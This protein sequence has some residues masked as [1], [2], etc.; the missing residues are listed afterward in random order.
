LR[1]VAIRRFRQS[2]VPPDGDSVWADGRWDRLADI[3]GS[4]TIGPQ[5]RTESSSTMAKAAGRMSEDRAATMALDCLAFLA[6]R[7]DAFERFSDLT[8]LDPATIAARA[9]ELDFLVAVT[10]FLLS[11]EGL[12]IDFCETGSVDARDIHMARHVLGGR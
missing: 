7:S 9:G 2:V 8:G 5:T 10:D 12:L 11:D 4:A 3:A 6:T 1:S